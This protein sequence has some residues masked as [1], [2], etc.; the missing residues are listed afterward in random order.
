AIVDYLPSPVD[1][2]PGEGINPKTGKIVK[3]FPKDDEPL[4]A[5]AFKLMVDPYAGH[6]CFFR[7]Y[8]GAL[9]AG[10]YVYN[11]TRDVKER[12]GRLLRMH[13]NKREEIKEV[14]AGDICAVVGLRNVAT[15]DT[16][17]DPKAPI[18]LEAMQ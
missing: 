18:A 9:R 1:L 12:I 5:L 17:C 2:P 14:W 3:R 4:A 6:L 16:I 7:V 10:S 13:A 8:S 15:G 11:S